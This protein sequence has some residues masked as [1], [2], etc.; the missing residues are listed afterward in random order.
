[1]PPHATDGPP[2]TEVGTPSAPQWDVAALCRLDGATSRRAHPV[3]PSHQQGRRALEACRPA[4][5]GGHAARGLP[6]GGARSAS[7]ACRPRHCPTWQTLT[8]GQW[9][10]DRTAARLPGPSFPLVLSVPHALTPLLLAHKRPRVTRRG[11][12][13][14]QT[15]GPCGQRTRGGQSGCPMGL[16]TWAQTLGAHGPVHGV[17]AA[18][19][20]SA[21]GERWSA[22]DSRCLLPVRALST[23]L[24]GQG[25]EALARLWTTGALPLPEEPTTVG[26]PAGCAPLRAQLSATAWVGYA[27]PPCAGPAHVL[28]AVGR[29]PHRVALAHPRS[30]DGRDGWGRVASRTRRQDQRLQA[31]ALD[32]HA[33]IRRVLWPGCP[34]GVRRLRHDGCLAHRHKARTLRRCRALRGQPSTPAPR[35]PHSVGQ[36]RH[37]GT[38]SAL[39]HGPHGGARPLVRLPLPPLALPAAPR[40]APVEVPLCDAS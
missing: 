25:C 2:A 9:V 34:S 12:A 20:L 40:G 35:S 11:T 21:H 10:E 38:G 39:T 6:C 8:Q 27:Q 17:S 5:R 14:S 4:Q 15:L 7:H 33:G 31:M 26:I 18:G 36:W 13:A 30:L 19:A 23:V 37:E 16:P 22:A 29:A 32:A 3:P 28:D 24:R 1:M